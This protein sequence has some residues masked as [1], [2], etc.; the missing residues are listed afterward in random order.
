MMV[1]QERSSA[2]AS[3]NFPGY[4]VAWIASVVVI[5]GSVGPWATSGI[6]SLPGT[7]GD[8]KYTLALGGVAAVVLLIK[9]AMTNRWPLVVAALMGF[10][11]LIVGVVDIASVSSFISDEDRQ[12]GVVSVGWGLWM[13][14]VGTVLLVVGCIVAQIGVPPRAVPGID[15]IPREITSDA[16]TRDAETPAHIKPDHETIDVFLDFWSSW[17]GVLVMTLLGWLALAW[18]FTGNFVS[19]I[20]WSLFPGAVLGFLMFRYAR[21]NKSRKA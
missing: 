14:V 1:A 8:G 3:V 19:A 11:C 10:L 15:L 7:H 5:V 13:V 18:L 17:R 9:S 12:G 6:F 20:G 16:E 2:L 4:I 21:G